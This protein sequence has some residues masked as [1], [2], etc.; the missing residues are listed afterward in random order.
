MTDSQIQ[1]PYVFPLLGGRKVSN[2]KANIEALGLQL[3]HQ[4]IEEI[5]TGYDFDP[6]FPHNFIG[7]RNKGTSGPEDMNSMK[8]LGHFD[9]VGDP[10]PI[11]PHQGDLGGKAQGWFD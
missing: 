2:L 6:G 4:D 1:A 11:R 8:T 5:E 3:S 10:L 7:P 9:F